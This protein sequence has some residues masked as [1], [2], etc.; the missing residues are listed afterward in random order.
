MNE[1]Q[2]QEVI[3]EGCFFSQQRA[4]IS[5]IFILLALCSIFYELSTVHVL[6]YII[7]LY[8][9]WN[10]NLI[11]STVSLAIDPAS[12]PLPLPL[13]HTENTIEERILKLQEK[14]KLVFDGTVGGDAG[15]I[16]RLT[17]DDMRF[18]FQ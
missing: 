14:K 17:V 18:L 11:S 2:S 1:S 13:P 3:S 5:I 15:S 10:R 7:I 4:T 9:Y 12:L 8:H 16:A 6:I